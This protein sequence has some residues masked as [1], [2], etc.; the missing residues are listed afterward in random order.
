MAFAAGDII[1]GRI[2]GITSYGAFVS[3][4]E[5][6]SGL[7]HISEISYSFVNDVH[8]IL[9]E[10]QTVKVKVLSVD[11][12]GRINLSIKKA[13]DPPPRQ[14]QPRQQQRQ[15]PRQNQAAAAAEW[16]PPAQKQDISFE[17]RLKQFM[18][19]S[20]SKL[21]STALYKKNSSTRRGNRR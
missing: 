6:K 8:D 16:Q 1:E 17:D 18:Q 21:S 9:S 19:E 20:D 15:Q 5:G 10:G 3:L 7:V 13:A 2:S 14:Q 12:S 4:P 11:D